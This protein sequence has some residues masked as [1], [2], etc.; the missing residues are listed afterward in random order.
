MIRTGRKKKKTHTHKNQHTEESNVKAIRREE[1]I[2]H[3]FRNTHKIIYLAEATGRSL[4]KV[5]ILFSKSTD[6]HNFKYISLK[7]HTTT[8]AKSTD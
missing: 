6:E 4:L 2:K 8:S 1:F 7:I 3:H 5:L